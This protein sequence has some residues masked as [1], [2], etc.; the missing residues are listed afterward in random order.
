MK[1]AGA[2]DITIKYNGGDADQHEIDVRLLGQS[3]I[4]FERI[5]SDGVIYLSEGRLPKKGERAPLVIRANEPQAGSVELCMVFGATWGVLPLA[6]PLIKFQDAKIIFEWVAFVLKFISG[7][8]DAEGHMDAYLKLQ[9][10][11]AAERGATEERWLAHSQHSTDQL[12]Q[13]IDKLTT[14]VTKIGLLSGSAEHLSVDVPMAD[15]IRA[16]TV[17]EFSDIE[18]MTLL[19]DGFSH[20]SKT[21]KVERPDEPGKFMNAVIKDPAFDEVP[22]IYTQSAEAKSRISAAVKLAR[23]NGKL[24]QIY[25]LDAAEHT[26]PAS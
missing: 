19:V 5:I 21:L 2:P 14:S 17:P 20:H 25:I 11:H 1:G 22:N 16:K 13:L 8:G 18:K 12:H 15:A 10:L 9:E 26:G 6:L 7:K 3:L 23:K 24:E 4:G